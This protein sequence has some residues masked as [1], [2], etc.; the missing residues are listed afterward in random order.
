MGIRNALG[1]TRERVLRMV[2]GNAMR[3]AVI[4]VVVG[5]AASVALSRT[6][7]SLLFDL[8]ATDPTTYIAVGVGLSLVA[9]LASYLPAWRATRVDPVV[10]LR[11][12]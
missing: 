8:S 3:L 6:L 7:E 4:G 2:L 5:L 9:L 1:A 11:A 10:A 12:D